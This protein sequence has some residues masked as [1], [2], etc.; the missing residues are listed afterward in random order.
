MGE[1]VGTDVC[2]GVDCLFN[3]LGL[4]GAIGF[5]FMSFLY[6]ITGSGILLLVKVVNLSLK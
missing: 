1:A 5:G 6:L 2:V 4:L 3:F